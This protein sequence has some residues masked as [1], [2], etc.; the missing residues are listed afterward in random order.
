MRSIF[1]YHYI[2][3]NLEPK[4]NTARHLSTLGIGAGGCELLH[5]ATV[6]CP[7]SGQRRAFGQLWYRGHAGGI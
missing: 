1:F 7:A 3:S 4:R 6:R 2:S 5:F